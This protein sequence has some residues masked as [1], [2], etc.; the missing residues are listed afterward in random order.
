MRKKLENKKAELLPLKM[1]PFT[2]IGGLSYLRNVKSVLRKI[3]KYSNA[4]EVTPKIDF[5]LYS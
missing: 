4:F 1:H 2:Q 5:F 3:L